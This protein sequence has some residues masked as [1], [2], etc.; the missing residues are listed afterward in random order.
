MNNVLPYEGSADTVSIRKAAMN[1]GGSI[2]KVFPMYGDNIELICSY[3]SLPSAST[4]NFYVFPFLLEII[5][6]ILQNTSSF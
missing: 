6:S 4:N 2:P 3:I 5:S 1:F